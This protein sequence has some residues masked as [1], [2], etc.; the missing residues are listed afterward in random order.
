MK[1]SFVFF[2]IDRGNCVSCRYFRS[3]RRIYYYLSS[4]VLLPVL[5]L[6][7]LSFS[8]FWDSTSVSD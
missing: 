3:Q 6:F 7:L 8:F 2:D 1:R 4:D 5:F